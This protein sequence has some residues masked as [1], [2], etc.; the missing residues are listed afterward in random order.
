MWRRPEIGPA[1]PGQ[2]HPPA[3]PSRAGLG[4]LNS[5]LE[6]RFY[7]LLDPATVP[8]SVTAFAGRVGLRQIDSGN[9]VTAGDPNG[10]VVL[11][12]VKP[13]TVVFTLPEDEIAPVAALMLRHTEADAI[14]AAHPA[15]ARALRTGGAS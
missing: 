7:A 10:L 3:F 12:Q 8:D 4:R 11:A 14:I 6:V 15:M 2:A 13:I 9:Y 5:P 1:E